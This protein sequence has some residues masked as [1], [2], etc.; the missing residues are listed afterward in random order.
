MY[1]F[2]KAGTN[3]C[4][5]E[6]R[7]LLRNVI[8]KRAKVTFSRQIRTSHF[9]REWIYIY[10]LTDTDAELTNEMKRKKLW[11]GGGKKKGNSRTIVRLCEG[12][13]A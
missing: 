2:A 5:H 3:E 8:N 10:R 12:T 13:F 7:V 9:S 11:R 6:S 1:I 4:N